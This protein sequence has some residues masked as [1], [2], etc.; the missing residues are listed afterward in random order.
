M[1][2][3]LRL[4]SIFRNLLHKEQ[5][6]SDLDAEIR[7]YAEAVTDEK[8]AAGMRASEARRTAL[9]EIGGIESLKQS[10]RNHQAGTT[11]DALFQDHRFAVRTISRNYRFAIVVSLTLALGIGATTL[12]FDA[13]DS[14]LLH[15]FPYRNSARLAT[16]YILWPNQ[17]HMGRFPIPAYFDFKEQNHVFQDLLG[18]AFL[19]SV[20]YS[21]SN[22]T[23][24]FL[25]A[26]VS[27]NAFE[28]LGVQPLLGRPI[29]AADVE[30][31]ATPVF[32]MSYQLWVKQFNS[33][34]Q[35]LGRSFVLN[36]VART[37]IAVMPPRFR[38]GDFKSGW[39]I[40][41]TR[42]SFLPGYGLE[43]NELWIV[44]H[45]RHGI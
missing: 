1:G 31:Q 19:P 4:G 26:I 6:E 29:T 28:V 35:L 7:A 3:A 18:L 32:A 45:L 2:F 22:G 38:S 42:D 20:R 17:I 5:V 34:R 43:N 9:A 33:D 11:I 10:V 44:G 21:G 41:F 13:I 25:G 27:P 14:V 23:Q 40:S 24:Q 16:F 8:I 15:P 12:V 30:T 39:Q 36:G 37:L